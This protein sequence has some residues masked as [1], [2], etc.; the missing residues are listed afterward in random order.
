MVKS[1]DELLANVDAVMICSLDGRLHLKRPESVLKAASGCSSPSTRGVAGRCSSHFQ[2]RRANRYA[3]FSCSQ[4]RYS[5]GFSGMRNHPEVGKVL[6]CDVY[7]GFEIKGTA[8]DEFI[9]P[10]H[11]LGNDLLPFMARG[12]SA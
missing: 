2:T 3:V 1:V 12:S 10:L 8:A 7:G 4:H 5:P 6:G 9:R 11:S